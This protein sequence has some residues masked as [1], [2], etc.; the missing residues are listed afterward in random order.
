MSHTDTDDRAHADVAPGDEYPHEE[1]GAG[2]RSYLIGLALAT[3][4]TAASF[5]VAQTKVMWAPAIPVALLTF[6]IAQMG[7]HLVF[8]LH[9]TSGPDN[10]NNIM[11]LAFGVLIVFL[12]F[13]GS[14]WIMHH[15][16]YNMM[17]PVEG[18]VRM[19]LQKGVPLQPEPQKGVPMQHGGGGHH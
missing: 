11:A 17:A 13:G 5:W 8:F 7:V 16:N 18:G 6:A 19:P 1:F 14:V 10:T 9:L 15:M 3:L 12:L 2:L 4:L